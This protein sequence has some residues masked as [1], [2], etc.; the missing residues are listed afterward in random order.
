MEEGKRKKKYFFPTFLNVM[1]L[2]HVGDH[3]PP[4]ILFLYY[5]G[6]AMTGCHFK[7]REVSLPCYLTYSQRE[8]KCIHVISKDIYLKVNAKYEAGI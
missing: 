2:K 5:F 7:A 3:F 8:K 4:H 1:S 6:I